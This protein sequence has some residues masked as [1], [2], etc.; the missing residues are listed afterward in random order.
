MYRFCFGNIFTQSKLSKL[1]AL[2]LQTILDAPVIELDTIDSTNNYAMQLIDADTAQAGLTIIAGQQTQGKGQRGK[3]W[4]DVPSESL[5]MSLICTPERVLEDQFV[6]NAGVSVAIANVLLSIYENWDIRIKWPNDIIINDK[7][8]GGILIE[9]VIRGNSWVYSIIGIGLN[10]LQ[11][12]FPRY[13]PYATS[14]KCASGRNF[15]INH[16]AVQIRT[17]IIHSIY[18]NAPGADVMKQFND[19][20]YRRNAEQGF[21]DNTHT[22]TGLIKGV[23]ARGQLEVQLADG[24][25]VAY[26][27]GSVAWKWG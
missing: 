4:E 13:L 18:S 15:D 6:F 5:L 23:S 21:S 14:L 19:L 2:N 25:N 1:L 7:K 12:S 8:A 26:T 10:A 3:N 17:S 16:L 20:L 27:H 22:W 11:N 24:T 9:N